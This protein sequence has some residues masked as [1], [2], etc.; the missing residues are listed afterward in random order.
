M[1]YVTCYTSHFN[2]EIGLK[3]R[4]MNEV[5][6]KEQWRCVRLSSRIGAR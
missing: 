3:V 6:A 4:V 2:S 1:R 5:S